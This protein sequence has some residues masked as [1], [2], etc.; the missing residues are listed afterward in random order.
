MKNDSK[1]A[2]YLLESGTLFWDLALFEE[3][4]LGYH[5]QFEENST[6]AIDCYLLAIK[7]HLEQRRV[8]LAISLYSEMAA[9]LKNLYKYAQAT[10][11]FKKAAEFLEKDSP[12]SAVSL[13]EEATYCTLALKDYSTTFDLFQDVIQISSR[14]LSNIESSNHDT[15]WQNVPQNCVFLQS[16]MSARLSLVLICCLQNDFEKSKMSV[17][18]LSTDL[19]RIQS[20]LQQ[21]KSELETLPHPFCLL[22]DFVVYIFLND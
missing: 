10:E 8:H 17:F 4:A 19:N 11:Y 18:Q 14:F 16:L 13:I 3:K 2:H 22:P 12:L 9:N 20:T 1:E 5:T 15:T 7:I 21:K 6:Q